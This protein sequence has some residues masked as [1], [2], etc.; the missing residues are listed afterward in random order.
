MEMDYELSTDADKVL[1][2][3]DKTD[4]TISDWLM[5]FEKGLKELGYNWTLGKHLKLTEEDKLHGH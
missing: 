4:P 5:A 1:I 2:Q 3:S